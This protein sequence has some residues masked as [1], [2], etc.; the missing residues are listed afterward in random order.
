MKPGE[1]HA[2]NLKDK[3]QTVSGVRYD[4]IRKDSVGVPAAL[5]GDPDNAQVRFF[6]VST[7][8]VGNRSSVV[9]MNAA[10]AAGTAD[11]TGLKRRFKTVHVGVKKRF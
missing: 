10:V 5:T 1:V 6:P 8:K 3:Q 11:G 4:D 7:P 9:G 2:Q